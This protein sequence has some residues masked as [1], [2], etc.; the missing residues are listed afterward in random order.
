MGKASAE[1]LRYRRLPVRG[2]WTLKGPLLGRKESPARERGTT[3][4]ESTRLPAENLPLAGVIDGVADSL[5]APHLPNP[6]FSP[7]RNGNTAGPIFA[8][9]S[10]SNK[11]ARGGSTI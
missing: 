6:R 10:V 7:V 1:M 5:S 3:W 2:P 8:Q 4:L 9:C 11:S